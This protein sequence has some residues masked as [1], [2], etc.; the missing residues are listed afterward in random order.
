MSEAFSNSDSDSLAYSRLLLRFYN[1]LTE[2]TFARHALFDYIGFIRIYLISGIALYMLFGF[3]DFHVGGNSVKSLFFIRYAIACPILLAVFALSFTRSFARY[4]QIALAS[5]MITSGLGVVAMTAIMPAPFNSNYYAGLIMVVIYCGSFIRVDFVATVVIS[6]ALVFCYEMSAAFINPI[7]ASNFLSNNFF[8]LMSTAVGLLSGYIQETQTRK[9]YIAQRMIEAKNETANLLLLEANKANR[10]KSEFLA[11]MSHELRTPL[12]AI[13]GFSDLIDKQTFGPVGNERY[14][15]Y[16]KHISG[17]G[18]H[19]LEIINDILDL[20]K[21]DANKL[22]MVESSVELIA[23]LNKCTN[24]CAPK[25]L[26]RRVTVNLQTPADVAMVHADPKL[27]L[28]LVLNLVSNAVKFSHIGGEVDIE[29][30]LDVGGGFYIQVKDRGIGIAEE[31]IARVIRPFEQV[32]ASY[33]RQNGGTGLGLPLA[34]KLAELHGATLN[35]TSQL[36][37]G[38]S[39]IVTFPADRLLR[40][41]GVQTADE[42]SIAV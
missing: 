2:R 11:N 26:E 40:A 39:V 36:N 24:M 6:L 30:D 41:Q 28:Q 8:L 31:D 5:T 29:F 38:T 23:L 33:A 10:S 7:P 16:V 25:A 27:L 42:L 3:L 20:A 35:I 19:L 17:S 9:G 21:A 13:I 37:V 15:E 4:G 34:V 14:A 22:T 1:P 32:E 18:N 12:N